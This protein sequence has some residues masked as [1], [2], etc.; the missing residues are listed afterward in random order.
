M[1]GLIYKDFSL[2]YK[3]ID[4]KLIIIAAAVIILLLVNAGDFSGLLATIMFAMTV[5]MQNV[6]SFS[7]D[8]QV[9]WKKYQLTMPVNPFFAVGSKYVSVLLT[10]GLSI[11]AGILL[12]FISGIMY[13]SFDGTLLFVSVSAAI[14]I[15]LIWSAICLPLTYW[16]GFRSAQTMGLLVIVPIFY[17][18]KYFEDGPGLVSLTDT[19]STYILS[20]FLITIVLFIFSYIV[21]VLG[22][23]RKK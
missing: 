19:I 17:L 22:Y 13:Q 21:S 8:E 1:K 5:G 11:A 3:S 23:S 9:R 16:F 18:I 6:M 14:I 10:I 12:Y 20:G 2:F 15:P 7:S 4:K